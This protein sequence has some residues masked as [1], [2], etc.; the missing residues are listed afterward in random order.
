M[1]ADTE[2]VFLIATTQ[3]GSNIKTDNKFEIIGIHQLKV[4]TKIVKVQRERGNYQ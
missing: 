2:S 3:E 1:T 4:L